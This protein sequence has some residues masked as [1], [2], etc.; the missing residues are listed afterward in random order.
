MDRK[1]AFSWEHLGDLAAGRPNLGPLTRLEVYRLMQF[2][3]RDVV[4][5]RFGTAA[6]DETFYEAGALAGRHLYERLIAPVEGLDAFLAK[7]R[8]VLRD[9]KVG[10]L[11]VEESDPEKGRFVLTVSEDV[12]CS[13]LPD[14]SYEVC[15]YDEGLISALLES[16]TGRPF[17]VREIDCWSTGDRTCRFLAE[18]KA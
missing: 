15:R 3:F 7:L 2:C 8:D 10:V 9:L 18:A 12:D 6:A 13:G 17:A 1:Y 5:A 16:F 11:R 14:L 4:E